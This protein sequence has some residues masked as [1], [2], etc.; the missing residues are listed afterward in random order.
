MPKVFIITQG[1]DVP[2]KVPTTELNVLLILN[3]L[4]KAHGPAISRKSD[5][6][7][8]ISS[9]YKLLTRLTARNLVEKHIEEVTTLDI[10]QKIVFYTI[11]E[12]VKI[13]GN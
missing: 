8:S 2:V 5:G 10:K 4:K 6:S 7:I 13:E 1:K 9:V 3:K 12:Y 11:P